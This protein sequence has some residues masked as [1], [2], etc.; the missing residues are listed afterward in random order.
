MFKFSICSFLCLLFLTDLFAETV[1]LGKVIV[2]AEYEGLQT[3]DVS[4]EDSST[5]SSIIGKNSFDAKAQNLAEVVEKESSVQVRQSGG[6]GSFS[7]LSL[8]GASSSQVMVFMDGIPLNDS[9]GGGVDLSNI[10][11]S[12][13]DSIE[14]YKGVTPINFGRASIGGALNIKTKRALKEKLKADLLLGYGSFNSLKI[15]PFFSNK[16]GKFDYLLSTEYMSS[17]NNFTFLNDNGTKWNNNDDEYQKRNNAK[18]YHWN[19][20]LNFAYDISNDTR[21]IFSEQLFLKNQHLPSWNNRPDIDTSFY[22]LRN[23]NALKLIV[24]DIANKSINSATRLDFSYKKELYD[25]R[26]SG[27]GL[28]KQYDEYRTFSYGFNQFFEWVTTYNVLSSVFDLHKEDYKSRDLLNLSTQDP[29]S[30]IY[31]SIAVED[32]IIL[33][34]NSF[35]INPALV[36]EHY[37]NNFK[38]SAKP[39]EGEN[40]YLNPRMGLKYSLLNSLV[41]KTNLAKYVREPSFFELFGDRGLFVGNDELTAEK[42]IN[43]DIGIEFEEKLL[44]K[45]I[46]KVCFAVSYFRTDVKDVIS[47]VYNAR[48]VGKAMNISNSII[49]G[50]EFLLGLDFFKLLALSSSYT[51]QSPIN[52][53]LIQA[54]DGKVLPGRFRHSAMMRLE[55]N[56]GFLRLYYEFMYSSGLYYD[57]ANLLPADIKREHNAGL[58]ILPGNFIISFEVKNIGNHNYQDYNGYPQPGRS[59]WLTAKYSY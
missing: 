7:D 11:L 46:D 50:M 33:F 32:K 47:Y 36:F 41:L 51:R 5:F 21:L 15:A 44:V 3:G 6:L 13:V 56:R 34:D 14:V 52:R 17:K 42:G 1:S 27:V 26:N 35:I 20:L 55:N 24:N 18:F 59:Y 4:Q 12:D 58:T 16:Y 25:D 23:I 28:G 48:G 54:F 19:T 29:S 37:S 49:N 53:S 9:S 57:T 40:N 30:R 31:S 10:S 22:T 38:S 39:R 2:N 8:R 43:F 45:N